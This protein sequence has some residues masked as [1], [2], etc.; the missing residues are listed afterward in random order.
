LRR[1]GLE[2]ESE[3]EAMAE[4]GEASRACLV[5][6]RNGFRWFHVEELHGPALDELAKCYGLH[7]LALQDTRDERTRAKLEQFEGHFFIVLNTLRFNPATCESSY[8]EF[9]IFVGKEFLISAHDGPSRTAAAVKPRFMA[10]P[11]LAHPGRLLHALLRTIVSR[12]PPVLDSVEEKLDA[13]EDQV[14]M[15][16]TPARLNEI[17]RLKRALVDLRRAAISMREVLNGILLRDEVWL[18][19]QFL[20]FRDI[21]D[22]VLRALEFVDTYRDI[23][24]GVLDVH[25]TATANRTNEIMKVLTIF[26][27]LAT[28]FLLVTGFFGMNFSRLPWLDDPLGG[29]WATLIMAGIGLGML[30]YFRRRGWI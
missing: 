9:D 22:H 14:Y 6:E 4:L 11:H 19:S 7:E 21:Y 20:Y 18:K 13:L 5:G 24:T 12:Y 23:L 17:F 10:D 16:P 28:P 26:A 30:F 25:L 2:A 27:T 15:Q 3:H 29:L 1:A 8:G